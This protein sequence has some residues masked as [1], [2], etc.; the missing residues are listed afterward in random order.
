LAFKDIPLRT[1][2]GRRQTIR[3]V[4]EDYD[5]V[6]LDKPPGIPVVPDRWD[7]EKLNLYDLLNSL[8]QKDP[9]SEIEKIW[10]VHRIDQDTSGL[11]IF[12]KNSEGH[13]LLNKA[14]SAGEVQKSYL[15]VVKGCPAKTDGQIDFALSSSQKGRVVVDP[16]GKKSITKYRVI[17][18]FSR[19]SL[20]EVTPLTGRTHQIRV[21]LLAIGHPLA[22][23]PI[24]TRHRSFAITDIKRYARVPIEDR[25]A[26]I[27][28]LTLHA[29]ELK[30]NHP[31]TGEPLELK[32]EVPKD[33]MGVIKALRKWNPEP[34]NS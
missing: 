8:L 33:L 3:I 4:Y 23:D 16:D 5:L 7:P 11:V 22:V 14:F 6:V 34:L 29:M 18:K 30:L 19:F 2:E 21:H 12:A 17:E 25:P 13:Q 15:A 9:S 26:L 24:Y 27:S 28:R 10:V 20:L 1:S 31:K 32:A